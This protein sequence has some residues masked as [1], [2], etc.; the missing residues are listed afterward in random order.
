MSKTSAVAARVSTSEVLKNHFELFG[1]EPAYALDLEHLDRAYLDIQSQV[2]PDRHAQAGDAERRASMQMTTRVNEAHRTLKNPVQ[3]A[4]YLLEI[5]GVDVGFETDTAM[6]AEFL[7]EQIE[8]REALEGARDAAALGVLEKIIFEK[9]RVLEAQIAH[10]TDVL[11]EYA[12]AAGPVRKLMFLERL[13][14]EVNAAY[15]AFDG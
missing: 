9:K 15:E 14:E 12:A 7:M 2:H 13:D 4:K 6:P 10:C 8:L 11:K 3:R 5:N 1:L